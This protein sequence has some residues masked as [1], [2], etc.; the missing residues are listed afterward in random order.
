MPALVVLPIPSIMLNNCCSSM[1]GLVALVITELNGPMAVEDISISPPDEYPGITLSVSD[2]VWFLSAVVKGIWL[3][4]D[5]LR[6]A[7]GESS[8]ESV[9]LAEA[10]P[11]TESGV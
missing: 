11:L 3:V 8:W 4:G 10:E 1:A 9:T 5:N 7:L 2:C 6:S